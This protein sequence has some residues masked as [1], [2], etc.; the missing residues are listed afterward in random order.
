MTTSDAGA[1][2]RLANPSV[3][4]VVAGLAYLA[5]FGAGGVWQ[6]QL[7]VY[8]TAMGVDRATL[9]LLNAIP[10]GAMILAAPLWGIL[11]DRLGDVRPSIVLA[12]LLMIGV[13]A[14]LWLAPVVPLFGVAMA[15]SAAGVAGWPAPIDAWTIHALGPSR[16]RFGQARA[17]GSA[18]FITASLLTGMLAEGRGPEVMFAVYIPVM[19]AGLLWIVLTFRRPVATTPAAATLEPAAATLEPG[20]TAPEPAAVAPEAG[21]RA[22]LQLLRRPQLGW[23]FVGSVLA[24]AAY[25]GSLAYLSVRIADQSGSNGLVGV[26][27]ACNAIL[28]VPVMLAF[29]RIA[30]RAGVPQLMLLGAVALVLRN[31]AWALAPSAPVTIGAAALSGVGFA[32]MAVGVT[33]WL[34]EHV[35]GTMR[36]TA[37]ALFMTAAFSLGNITGS[38]AAGWLTAGWG[39][40]VMFAGIAVIGLG[41][42]AGLAMA[43]RGGRPVSAGTAAG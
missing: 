35:P 12:G 8:F 9:G 36:A 27:W 34:S 25:N 38:L 18:G 3:V 24:W 14:W 33:T 10:G 2:R 5:Y 22:A 16:N 31:V 42:V 21:P 23:L 4:V 15:I 19:V 37:Q 20:A 13:A 32:L 29:Q 39:L 30:R 41:G 11:A 7:P 17:F 26:G 6:P 43:V 40:E 28:E 1:G